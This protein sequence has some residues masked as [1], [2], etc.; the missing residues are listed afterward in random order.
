MYSRK[1]VEPRMEPWGTPALTGC[2]CKDFPSRTIQSCLLLRKDEIRLKGWKVERL[3]YGY[4]IRLCKTWNS[5]RCKFVKKI[6]MSNPVK[7]LACIKS[8]SSGSPRPS[9]SPGNSIRYNCHKVCNGTRRP[10]TT[11]E[12]RKRQ[13]FSRW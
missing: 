10:K 1:S 3:K 12:I 9:K 2:S 4:V 6:G 13:H 5:I 8:Y 11:L 7:S